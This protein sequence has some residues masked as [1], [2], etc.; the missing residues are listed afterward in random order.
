MFPIICH[1]SLAEFVDSGSSWRISFS[2]F[3]NFQSQPSLPSISHRVSQH[4]SRPAQAEV[5]KFI[6]MGSKVD[7]WSF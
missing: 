5:L 2:Q 7:S 1:A 4:H 3:L 6:L